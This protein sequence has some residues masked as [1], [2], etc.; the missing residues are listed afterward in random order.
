MTGS[1]TRHAHA[2]G[3]S[4][5]QLERDAALSRVS[6][7][8]RWVFAGAAALT[9]GFAALVASVAP[10]R[11]LHHATATGGAATP[12]VPA[13]RG[14][15]LSASASPQLPPLASPG[16]LG[17]Q[18]PGQAPQSAPSQQQSQSAPDPSQAAAQTAASQ[19]EP[20]PAAPAP[21][22]AVSGGS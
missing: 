2:R 14:K 1:Q 7:A 13:A 10:G 8:R 18:S 12:T 21:V 19:P 16:E 5:A 6:R 20:A 9:A 22:P 17:L 15:T 11:T 4:L 3:P